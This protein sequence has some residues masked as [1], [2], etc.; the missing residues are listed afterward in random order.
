V[1][2]R[3]I[4]WNDIMELLLKDY[5]KFVLATTKAYR[6]SQKALYST[7]LRIVHQVPVV[8]ISRQNIIITFLFDLPNGNSESAMAGELHVIGRDGG[9]IFIEL[10]CSGLVPLWRRKTNRDTKTTKIWKPITI[11]SI[12]LG[13]HTSRSPS[14]AR[15][16]NRADRFPDQ[17]VWVFEVVLPYI[18]PVEISKGL[19]SKQ[20]YIEVNQ[21]LLSARL[22]LDADFIQRGVSAIPWQ[23]KGT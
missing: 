22:L 19:R 7:D 3:D 13:K 18:S 23:L 21:A 4:G 15:K 9:A 11:L 6:F 16:L 8:P 12:T 10:V 2:G 14:R 20:K 17:R 1:K 5:A